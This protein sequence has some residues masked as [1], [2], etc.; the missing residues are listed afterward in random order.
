MVKMDY[1]NGKIYKLVSDETKKIFIGATCSSLS[2][3]LYD[4]KREYEKLKYDPRTYVQKIEIF[5]TIKNKENVEIVLI[6]NYECKDKNELEAR[7]RY[8][9]E[10]FK[11]KAFNHYKPATGRYELIECECGGTFQ[12][13]NRY[14]HLQTKKHKDSLIGDKED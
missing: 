7:K 12:K 6:E 3:R 13:R 11:D 1:K 2:K 4:H 10:K 5:R 14:K 9:I 8:W